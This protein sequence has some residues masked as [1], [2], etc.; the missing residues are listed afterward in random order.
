[1]SNDVYGKTLIEFAE[2][3][4]QK[5]ERQMAHHITEACIG[6]GA[7]K[8]V[9]PV[10]AITGE[11]KAVHSI[12]A[13]KCIDCSVCGMTCTKGTVLDQN[14]HVVP[15]VK[16]ADRMKPLVHRKDCSAC[17]ICGELC[18]MDAIR[19]SEP[20]FKGDLNVYAEINFAR[21]VGCGLCASNCPMEAMTMGRVEKNVPNDMESAAN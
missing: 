12:D 1:M 14:G 13:A 18:H 4:N 17:F 19:K 2:I 5:R 11:V 16:I 7:C 21:C 9:C 8:K 10:S 15:R 3:I 20:G 6:C